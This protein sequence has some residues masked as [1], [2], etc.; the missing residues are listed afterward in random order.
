MVPDHNSKFRAY[1]VVRRRGWLQIHLRI[2]RESRAPVVLGGD[3][4][5][6]QLIKTRLTPGLV[7]C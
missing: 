7:A 6:H 2:P 4:H 1:E 5:F 3:R